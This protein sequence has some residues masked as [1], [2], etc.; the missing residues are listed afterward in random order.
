MV[1]SLLCPRLLKG[2]NLVCFDSR[3][4]STG[5]I[6]G[7]VRGK[8]EVQWGGHFSTC[9]FRGICSIVVGFGVFARRFK[10]GAFVDRV[11]G[12]KDS[13]FWGT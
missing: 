12:A 9:G 1:L 6:P 7:I 5:G 2:R 10:V 13:P 8:T 4:E 3:G 11:A